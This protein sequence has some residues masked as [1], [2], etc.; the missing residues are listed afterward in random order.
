MSNT[1]L[2][3]RE[4]WKAPWE[5]DAQGQPVA[6]ADWVI[7]PAKLADHLYNLLSDK[8]RLQENVA[9]L[10]GERDEFKTK[11]KAKEAEGLTDIDKL[12]QEL[13][14]AKEQA[15]TGNELE[16]ARYRA[17]A[18][19]GLN[20]ED[21]DRLRGKTVDEFFE[22]AEK[23]AAKY[24]TKTEVEPESSPPVQ[25]GVRPR[26]AG[27]PKGNAPVEEKLDPADI[28]KLIPM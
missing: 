3:K 2:P 9:T 14:D 18:R 27:D 13:A 21:A 11:F 24:G 1:K 16:T 28:D 7:D 6:E 12:R 17:A 19:Y 20:D 23:F 4:E 8:A 22:D 5:T 25:R 15:K 10:T 26:A